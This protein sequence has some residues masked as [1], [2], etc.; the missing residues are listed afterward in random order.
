[1]TNGSR[2]E[3]RCGAPSDRRRSRSNRIDGDAWG[4]GPECVSVDATAQAVHEAW[5]QQ[6]GAFG[7]VQGCEANPGASGCPAVDAAVYADLPDPGV[8]LPEIDLPDLP[9]DLTGPFTEGYGPQTQTVAAA[10]AGPP[11]ECTLSASKPQRY[12]NIRSDYSMRGRATSFCFKTPKRAVSRQVA[13]ASLQRQ[14]LGGGWL[15]LDTK[16]DSAPGPGKVTS[17]YAFYDCDHIDLRLYRTRA[18]G[19]ATINGKLYTDVKYAYEDWTCP[20]DFLR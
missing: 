7:E 16:Q 14:F 1:M 13:I 15:T 19:F 5:L 6:V 9:I 17:P 2:D 11:R 10:A 8:S 3:T 18:L 20:D 12:V 4:A